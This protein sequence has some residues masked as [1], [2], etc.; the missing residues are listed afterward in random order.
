MKTTTFVT[1]IAL[2]LIYA[3]TVNSG[4]LEAKNEQ[5]PI[6][7]LKV[8]A[9]NG[10]EKLQLKLASIYM[11]GEGGVTADIEQAIY[12]YTFAAEQNVGYAQQK[13]AHIYLQGTG[14]ERSHE[15][16]LYWLNRAA[17]L[18]FVEAQLELSS[19]YESG[20]VVPQDL[21]SAHKWLSIAESL[22]EL[23]IETRQAELEDKMSWVQLARSK[24]LS[25]K[26]ILQEYQDC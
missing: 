19:L 17:N 24:Y 1:G 26:C 8:E 15:K 2:I 14:V 25:R 12:W 22:A 23:D 4:D 16:A 20:T 11:H 7:Q 21:V 18:G 5:M 9:L 3:S 10:N 6:D 13:L